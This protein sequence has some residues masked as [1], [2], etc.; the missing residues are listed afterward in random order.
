M[1]WRAESILTNGR[2]IRV[3]FVVPVISHVHLQDATAAVTA[4][5]MLAAGLVVARQAR[6]RPLIFGV[7]KS[8]HCF[9]TTSSNYIAC[10]RHV[11]SSIWFAL[12]D[13]IA[14]L[15]SQ[16][17][18]SPLLLMMVCVIMSNSAMAWLCKLCH[19]SPLASSSMTL[20][21]HACVRSA[22]KSLVKSSHFQP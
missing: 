1:P 5:P 11:T 4:A 18:Y 17:S 16:L 8:V 9:S 19:T 22:R 2:S 14:R 20:S 12:R 7:I 15:R 3:E 10:V 21:N 13:L 6:T